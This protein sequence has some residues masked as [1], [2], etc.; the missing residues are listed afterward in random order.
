[1]CTYITCPES[2]HDQIRKLE[3]EF[4]PG[5][6]AQDLTRCH[7]IN[8]SP[9][10]V[11]QE[12]NLRK[13]PDRQWESNPQPSEQLWPMTIKARAST[14]TAITHAHT[15]ART[16][17]RTHEDT[18]KRT[19]DRYR[20]N[21][22]ICLRRWVLVVYEMMWDSALKTSGDKVFHVCSVAMPKAH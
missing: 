19:A 2:L 16:H 18:Q 8:H 20:K 1:M 5:R 12:L 17:A 7:W 22:E 11:G 9:Y 10:I 4:N 6:G 13:L 15:H 14:E 21:L 3:Q